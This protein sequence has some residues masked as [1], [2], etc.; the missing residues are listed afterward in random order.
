[1]RAS[2]IQLP[3]V[4]LACCTVCVSAQTSPQNDYHQHLL[5]PAVA[6]LVG[7]LKPFTATDLISEMDAA[8]IRHSLVLS[9][10]YQY[11]KP[12]RPAVAEEYASVMAENDWTAAQ[13]SAYPERLSGACGVDPLKAYAVTEIERCS[14]IRALQSALKLHF[15]NSDVDLDNPEHVERLRTV[16]RAAHRY[17]MRIIV[18]LHANVTYHRPYG[19]QEARIFL[20]RVLPE[21]GD[22]A[23]Q[24]AHLA[25]SGGFDDPGTL[26]ALDVFL[27][28]IRHNEARVKHLYFDI[29]G[30]AGLG[31]WDSKR[32]LIAGMIRQ[33]EVQRVLFGSDG[34]WTG[35]TPRKA[36]DA[37]R[38]LPLTWS[39]F[40]SINQNVPVTQATESHQRRSYR[41]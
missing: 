29:S 33:I 16:F 32:D 35:F 15:G 31:D 36:L 17:N 18:H 21:A 39:E 41:R 1:M 12:H 34:A 23:V 4:L 38:Q 6:K 14:H 27:T 13:V 8:G 20:S 22:T 7:E 9:L 30:V 37:Y 24:I 40:Q 19:T 2:L 5:S 10:A 28:A 11:G 3:L 25:G 26:E